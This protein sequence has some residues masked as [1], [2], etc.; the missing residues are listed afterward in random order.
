VEAI[1]FARFLKP[2]ALGEGTGEGFLRTAAAS[3]GAKRRE[4]PS[5]NPSLRGRGKELAHRIIPL[6]GLRRMVN[7]ENFLIPLAAV[8]VAVLAWRG[9]LSERRLARVPRRDLD[10]GWLE[11][12]GG[13]LLPVAVIVLSVA[14]RNPDTQP[15][16]LSVKTAMLSLAAQIVVQGL[17]AAILIA[18]ALER[19]DGWR[20]A[21]LVPRRPWRDVVWGLVATLCIPVVVF[22]VMRMAVV[23]GEVLEL[24]TPKISHTTLKMMRDSPAPFVTALLVFG[25]VVVAPV[26][27]EITFRGLV[28]TGLARQWPLLPRWGVIT[29][30]ALVFAAVHAPVAAWQT[31]PALFVLGLA[32]GWLYEASGSLLPS[33][34]LH[35]VFNAINV[36]LFFAGTL[37][38]PPPAGFL[39]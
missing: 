18:R 28:Q 20:E 17:A 34:I 23:V 24:Q 7:V 27:E 33:V 16:A 4:E 12:L 35:A 32:L 13:L 6:I 29:A 10:I 38:A 3:G 36:V 30:A 9:L 8:I 19:P 22:G 37:S 11:V 21:G 2:L 39:P 5:P 31:L 1:G 15:P 26:L 14:R 25:A